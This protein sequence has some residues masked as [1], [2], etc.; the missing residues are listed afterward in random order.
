[1]GYAEKGGVA[2]AFITLLVLHV[3]ELRRCAQKDMIIAEKDKQNIEFQDKM[4]TLTGEV[5]TAL[6]NNILLLELLT[7]GR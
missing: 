3:I 6:S 5:K 2:F 1:M 4:L 7:R